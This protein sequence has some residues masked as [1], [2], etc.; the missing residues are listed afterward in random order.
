MS[1]KV[2]VRFRDVGNRLG[3]LMYLVIDT[4]STRIDVSSNTRVD[5]SGNTRV[6]AGV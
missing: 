5:A 4:S 6:T 1:R 3:T 2:G